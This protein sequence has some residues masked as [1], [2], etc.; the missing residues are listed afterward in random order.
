MSPK[1]KETIW[2]QQS[3]F[4]HRFSSGHVWLLG[5]MHTVCRSTTDVWHGSSIATKSCTHKHAKGVVCLPCII[6]RYSTRDR[7]PFLP[8][9]SKW[10]MPPSDNSFFSFGVVFHFHDCGRKGIL[11]PSVVHIFMHPTTCEWVQPSP[12]KKN[13]FHRHIAVTYPDPPIIMELKMGP[14]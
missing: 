9:S 4:N 2:I 7:L 12:V 6:V 1:K 3:H 13:P 11:F 5:G 8:W 14:N 10:K